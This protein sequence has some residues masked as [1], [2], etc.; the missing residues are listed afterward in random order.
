ME[1]REMK[2]KIEKVKA[3]VP[4]VKAVVPKVKKFLFEDVWLADLTAIPFT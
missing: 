4:K 2:K 1:K 3:V